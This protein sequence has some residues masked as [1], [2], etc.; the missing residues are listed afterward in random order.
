LSGIGTNTHAQVDTHLASISNPHTVT[1]AQ[2]GNDTAQWNASKL[3]GNAVDTAAPA[4]LQVLTWLSATS[5]WTPADAAAGATFG[6]AFQQAESAAQSSTTSSSYQQ[7]L[8]LT[9]PSL[10]AGTYRIGYYAE[11]WHGSTSYAVSVRCQL[12]DATTLCEATNEPSDSDN[13]NALG[14]FAYVSLT[15]A[16]HTI[17][18]DWKSQDCGCTAYIRNARLEIWRVS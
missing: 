4:N 9:T 17:D 13:R 7:K 11:Y 3:Q 18:I 8:R 10:I 5:K 15:A 14:G 1:A 12:D 16:A 6:S 2:V